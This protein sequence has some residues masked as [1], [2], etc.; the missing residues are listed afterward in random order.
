MLG[1]KLS[2]H[3][4]HV[5]TFCTRESAGKPPQKVRVIFKKV[6]VCFEKRVMIHCYLLIQFFTT[7]SM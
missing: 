7:L 2:W 4:V 5:V 6:K 1:V 3:F